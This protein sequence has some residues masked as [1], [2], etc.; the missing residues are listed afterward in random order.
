MSTY[1]HCH[2]EAM[3]LLWQIENHLRCLEEKR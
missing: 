2:T 1:R 3:T